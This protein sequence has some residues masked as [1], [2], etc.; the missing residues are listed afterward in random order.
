MGSPCASGHSVNWLAATKP[1]CPFSAW[2]TGATRAGKALACG[3]T[4]PPRS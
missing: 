1:P 2:A 3:L 4:A